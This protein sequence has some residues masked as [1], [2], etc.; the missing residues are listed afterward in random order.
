MI[1]SFQNKATESI[2][3]GGPSQKKTRS[4]LPLEL[5]NKAR[6]QLDLLNR[7]RSL[8]NLNAP[9]GNKLERLKGNLKE[10][11]SIR[12]NSQ[13]RIVFKW[14]GCDAFDVLICDYHA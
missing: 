6:M 12:I 1:V 10:F 4:S 2:F 3:D 14:T 13:W 9:P 7:T 5:H 11:Y 8:E